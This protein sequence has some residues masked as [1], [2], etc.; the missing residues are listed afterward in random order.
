MVPEPTRSVT[1]RLPRNITTQELMAL[2]YRYAYSDRDL[3]EDWHR[4][5]NTNLYKTGSQFKP[6]LK[7]CQ[8]FCD[9]FWHIENRRGLSFH[10]AWQDPVIMDQVRQ[11]GL[12][13]MSQLWLS[14]IRRAV[15]MR[16]GLAN[17]SFYRPHFA[18]QICQLTGLSQ[19]RVFDP[20][21]GWG[22]RML[23]TASANWHYTG[24]DTNRQ[25]FG[26]LERMVEFL[27]IQTQVDL[28]C[29]PVEQFDFAHCDPVDVVVTSPPYFDLEVYESSDQQCYNQFDSYS[30][31]RDQWFVPTVNASIALL[32]PSG[33]SAWNVMNV[34]RW[35]LTGDLIHAH[36]K[37]GWV[38]TQT[39]GFQSPLNNIRR[40]KNKDVTYVFRKK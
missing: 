38:L 31:W 10:K 15:Y 22:G 3:L 30:T 39:V 34:G 18:R 17:S 21:M 37:Q 9:N 5:C 2:D 1:S 32:R 33:I 36:N 14:W 35:D 11:W 40:L 29:E 27:D 20:C 12:Q 25:T 23:G 4:L 13:G 26:N 7:L 28:H 19:G 8:H 6:G 16:A 24:C